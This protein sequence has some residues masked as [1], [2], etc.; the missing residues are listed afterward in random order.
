MLAG[1][2]SG[3]AADGAQ[4]RARAEAICRAGGQQL[5]AVLLSTRR[6]AQNTPFGVI[7]A[8]LVAHM[9]SVAQAN[10]Q[11][12][13][14]LTSLPWPAKAKAA[15]APAFTLEAQAQTQMN[16]DAAAASRVR[17]L[18]AASQLLR[19]DPAVVIPLLYRARGAWQQAGVTRWCP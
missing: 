16:A 14:Q 2:G 1:C 11:R 3:G 9:R 10:A 17:D 12:V 19:R 5:Q 6:P 8:Q 7:R 13:Q 4:V 18:S 15:V